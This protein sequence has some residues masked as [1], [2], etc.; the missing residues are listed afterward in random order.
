M[1][2]SNYFCHVLNNEEFELQVE[3]S[4]GR[5]KIMNLKYIRVAE[6]SRLHTAFPGSTFNDATLVS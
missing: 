6:K 1:E 4:V 3:I 5:H 2:N